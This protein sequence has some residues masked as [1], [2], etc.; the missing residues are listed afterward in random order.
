MDFNPSI[1]V[2]LT[3]IVGSLIQSLK[4]SKKFMLLLSISSVATSCKTLCR[5]RLQFTGNSPA[6]DL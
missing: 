1:N 6:Q 4:R 3:D 2:Q 5:S